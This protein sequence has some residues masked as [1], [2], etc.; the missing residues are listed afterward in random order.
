MRN[1]FTYSEIQFAHAVLE[2]AV[3]NQI[4]LNQSLKHGF[5]PETKILLQIDDDLRW[6]LSKA[7]FNPSQPR[8]PAGNSNGGQW[9]EVG[10]I[11][12]NSEVEFVKTI[13]PPSGKRLDVVNIFVG[14][15]NDSD[16]KY[17][18]NSASLNDYTYGDNYFAAW[19]A[20]DS[21]LELINRIP[22]GRKINL[23]GHSYGG[24]TAAKVAVQ[25]PKR[26]NILITIDP[27]SN[28][29]KRVGY[30]DIA[31]SV[32]IWVNVNAVGNPNNSLLGNAFQGGAAAFFGDAWNK[33]PKDYSDIYLEAPY[34]HADFR[35]MIKFGEQSPQNILNTQ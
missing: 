15:A 11:E 30:S 28:R 22:K 31:Q 20:T 4:L 34:S 27:V 12:G 21:I 6:L 32:G 7:G 29:N 10:A 24:D 18:R 1:E 16:Y 23:I 3:K 9:T 8:V 26:I 35:Q 13:L 33:S 19:D 2:L 5:L 25:V 17:V 14:G